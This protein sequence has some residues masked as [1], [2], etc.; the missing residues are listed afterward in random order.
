MP[1]HGAILSGIHEEQSTLFEVCR[2]RWHLNQ[3]LWGPCPNPIPKRRR[4]TG[5][6][7]FLLSSVSATR[8]VRRSFLDTQGANEDGA[9]SRSY[10][11]VCGWHAEL[12]GNK[13]HCAG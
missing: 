5:V 10:P 13:E 2:L 1:V 11:G 8:G 4:R 3:G 7:R 12:A 9:S 6:G